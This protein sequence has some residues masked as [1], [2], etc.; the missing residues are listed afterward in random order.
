MVIIRFPHG[1]DW[2]KANWAFRQFADD[3]V[4]H[5]GGDPEI[6]FV[7]RHGT[8]NHALFL[9]KLEQDLLKRLIPILRTVASETLVG[10]IPGWKGTHPDD[11][12]GIRMYGDA[13]SEL[14]ESLSKN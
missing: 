12:A 10:K 6:Q 13:M 9:D 11:A 2:Y 7:M 14:I 5:A 3:V 4:A 1:G 8:A